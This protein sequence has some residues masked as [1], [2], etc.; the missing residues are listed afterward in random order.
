MSLVIVRTSRG[1]GNFSDRQVAACAQATV[2]KPSSLAR[3]TS[4][5]TAVTRRSKKDSDSLKRC[6]ALGY[7]HSKSLNNLNA[8][9]FEMNLSHGQLSHRNKPALSASCS[10][11]DLPLPR[12]PGRISTLYEDNENPRQS[13]FLGVN[14]NVAYTTSRDIDSRPPCPPPYSKSPQ[15]SHLY[16]QLDLVHTSS[17]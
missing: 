5:Q 1:G 9:G 13:E 6:A 11:L 14:Q 12:K 15:P 16:E 17:F 7:R 3:S 8:I 4:A 10:A 2:R